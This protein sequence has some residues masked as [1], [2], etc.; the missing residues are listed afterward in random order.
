MIRPAQTPDGGGR[1]VPDR[2][3]TLPQATGTAGRL[4][5][6]GQ[7]RLLSRRSGRGVPRQDGIFREGMPSEE[8]S[9]RWRPARVVLKRAGTSL[10]PSPNGGGRFQECSSANRVPSA[11]RGRARP[12]GKTRSPH[13]ISILVW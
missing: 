10:P 9:R 4:P 8:T 6:R 1:D 12:S 5:C 11:A 13:K 7:Q 3:D 2:Y